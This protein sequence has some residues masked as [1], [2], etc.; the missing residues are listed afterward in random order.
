MSSFISEGY[1]FFGNVMGSLP[2]RKIASVFYMQILHNF[3]V[4]LG[5]PEP[6][7]DAASG[8]LELRSRTTLPKETDEYS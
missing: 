8:S 2:S 7:H 3:K 1:D 4:V 5:R 6:C